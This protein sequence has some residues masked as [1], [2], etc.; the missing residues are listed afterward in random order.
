MSE[1]WWRTGA[2][3][4]I[5]P[6]SFQDS[7]GD[8]VGDLEGIRHRLDYLAWLGVDALWISPFYPSPMHDFGYDVA[9]YC[10]VDPVFGS[11][12][13]FDSLVADAHARGFKIILDFVPNHTSDQHPWFLESRSSRQ[14]PKP[15]ARKEVTHGPR[16]MV[17]TRYCLSDI[18]TLFPR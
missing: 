17:A 13:S 4:H 5:Y 7:N 2:I 6:R 15:P 14:S 18:T 3:Y 1:S 11:L 12:E 16:R 9:D 10:G 8:G